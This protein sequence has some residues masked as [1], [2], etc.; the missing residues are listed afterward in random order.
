MKAKGVLFALLLGAVPAAAQ[1][2]APPGA[3]ACSGC[4]PPRAGAD[5][6]AVQPLA[7]RPAG[8]IVEAMRAF[9]TGERSATVM[10]RIAKGFSEEETRP[11]AAWVGAQR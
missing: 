5:A 8:E 10:D 4:H 7:G 6:L 1:S 9:R 11:I 3:A 2:P